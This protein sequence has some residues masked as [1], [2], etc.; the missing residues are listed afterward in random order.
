MAWSPAFLLL[1]LVAPLLVPVPFEDAWA[2]IR[3]YKSWCEGNYGWQEFMAPHNNHPS[4]PGKLIYFF[5]LH[6]LGGNVALLPLIGW[7]LSLVISAG[8][9]LLTRSLWSGR[10]WRGA[11]IMLCVN[12]I[13]FSA[14]A[15]HSWTWEFVFQNF[16]PGTSFIVALVLLSRPGLTGAR[17]A[18]AGLV[19][20]VGTFAFGSGFLGGVILSASV[21]S[22]LA[23][24][25][26][27]FRLLTTGVW[28]LFTISTTWI[29]LKAFGNATATG[30][31]GSRVAF[32]LGQPL[33]MGQFILLLLGYALGNGTTTDPADL[34]PLMGLGVT[35]L[36]VISVIGLIRQHRDKALWRQALPCLLVAIYGLCNASLI[37]YG[38]MR[39]SLISAMASRYIVF[40]LFFTLGTLLLVLVVILHQPQGYLR[41]LAVNSSGPLLGGFL[42][43]QG[44]NWH[45]GYQQILRDHVRMRQ[46]AA[47]LGFTSILPPEANALWELPGDP[48][49][50]AQ[51]AKFLS[52]RG[53]LP[54]VTFATSAQFST[55]RKAPDLSSKWAWFDTPRLEGN[56]LRLYGAAGLSK[57]VLSLPDA[58]IITVQPAGGEEKILAVA[59]TEV[60]FDFYE[61][62][63]RRRL[64][65]DHYF[66]WSRELTTD[67]LP[68]G[69]VTL[70][71]YA[72]DVEAKRVRALSGA[73]QL[74]L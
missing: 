23:D 61:N 27:R 47:L 73:H 57:D 8:V 35:I 49:G 66:G 11:V 4:V 29:A 30:G 20:M 43:V 26:L 38:R 56:V 55:F 67:L 17:L 13:V 18:G 65:L 62:E 16:I 25:P 54:G 69:A 3:Q 15:G 63:W 19:S 5:V 14:A 68:K 21:W 32:L 37:G 48:H 71:A 53:E 58:I 40:T 41:R 7:A 46:E 22:G 52:G 10:P 39:H 1:F 72:Y 24:R 60:P 6:S 2:F 42:V 45:W 36:L 44:F 64:H 28:L 9:F 12:L 74:Q 70:K 59:R 50:V 33:L 51:L 34:C 31:E